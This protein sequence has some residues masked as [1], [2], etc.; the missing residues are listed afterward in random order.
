MHRGHVGVA[1]VRRPEAVPARPGLEVVEGQ[2]SDEPAL[3]TAMTGADAVL[4]AIGPR[5]V[6]DLFGTDLMRRTLPV[7]AAAMTAAGVRRLVL[8]SAFGVGGTAP[9]A[10][11][12][13]PRSFRTAM[14]ALYQDKEEA[15]D[16]LATSGLDVTT[17][18]PTMLTNSAPSAPP[19]VRD[20][21]T[22][23]PVD[24]MPRIPR[25]AVATAMLDAAEDP[26]T[27]GKRLLV[28]LPGKVR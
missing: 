16:R 17:V 24:G 7:V 6:K 23:T 25:S 3:T 10:T 8:L 4:C 5:G 27:V 18:Y 19:T 21:A 14:R 12:N 28:T 9:A 2:L 22:V 1:Y 26:G 20:T 13:A 15:E 11:F